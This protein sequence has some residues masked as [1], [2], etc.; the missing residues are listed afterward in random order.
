[1]SKLI[2]IDPALFGA[3]VSQG[4]VNLNAAIDPWVKKNQSQKSPIVVVDMYTGFDYKT[5]TKEG[6]HPNAKGDAFMANRFFSAVKDAL[7]V[8]TVSMLLE[9]E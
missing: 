9:N 2:P 5:M 4:I 3:D 8:S 1:M 6:E 7:V